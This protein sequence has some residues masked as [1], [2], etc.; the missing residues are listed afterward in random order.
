MQFS[1]SSDADC[2]FISNA[3]QSVTSNRYLCSFDIKQKILFFYHVTYH[4]GDQAVCMLLK[5]ARQ[6][7]SALM[8][9]YYGGRKYF[10]FSNLRSNI[11]R[12]Y[13]S[14]ESRLLGVR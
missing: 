12:I 8:I 2:S 4:P 6:A 9:F 11:I 5:S 10:R 14:Y 1:T 13:L 7:Y 3:L